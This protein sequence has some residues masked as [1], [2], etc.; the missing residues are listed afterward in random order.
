M[1]AIIVVCAGLVAAVPTAQKASDEDMAAYEI[2]RV[3]VGRDA[4]AHVKL[5]LWCEAHGLE[6]ERTKHLALAVLIDPKQATARGLMGMVA[7]RNR[8][9][10]PSAVPDQVQADAV[11]SASLAEYNGR[12]QKVENTAD[13]QWKLALWCEERGLKAEAEAHLAT[14]ARLDP[15]REAA[16]KRLGCKKVGGR[17]LTAAQIEAEKAEAEAQK[18]A[19]RHWRPLQTKWRGWLGEKT[20]RD[21]AQRYLASV[22]DPRAVP[23]VLAVFAAGDARHQV[24]AVQILGQIDAP[25]ASRALAMLAVFGSA[26]EVRRVAMETLKRRDAR[27]YAGILIAMLQDPIPYEVRP[28]GGPGAPGG[29]FVQGKPFNI[30]RLYSPPAPLIPVGPTDTFGYDAYGRPLL[31]HYTPLLFASGRVPGD[32]ILR[33]VEADEQRPF[34]NYPSLE[35]IFAQAGMSAALPSAAQFTANHAALPSSVDKG[36]RSVIQHVEQTEHTTPADFGFRLLYM[37][38]NDNQ[39]PIGQ[40]MFEAQKSAA[41]AQAQLQNDV[42]AVEAYNSGVSAGNDRVSRALC[43]ATGQDLGD[44]R[45]AWKAWWVNQLGYSYKSPQE[46]PTP[47]FVENV[48]LAYTPQPVIYR[49]ESSATVF[50]MQRMSCFGAGTLVRT[51]RGPEAIESLCVGDQV[52]SQDVKTGALSYQ[53]I[54]VVHHNPPSPT[55]LIKVGEE[56]IVSSPFHRFWRVGQGWVMARDLKPGYILR[57]LDGLSTVV[58][59]ESGPVQPVYNLDVSGAHD[60]FAGAAGALV[61][62]NTLPSLHQVPFDAEP[63]LTALMPSATKP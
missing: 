63:S 23:S 55:F 61:H 35:K 33:G 11:L 54:L 19:D 18:Q 62:D 12:R 24:L 15:S 26:D 43:A 52:L 34:S 53:P 57:L 40:V 37:G 3:S 20:R 7:F 32:Q 5:A 39:I 9:Q 56:T 29:L 10:R 17:W 36:V 25:A 31:H 47:T 28:V 49:I 22:D 2:A 4:D 8:W 13:A 1:L 27:E 45:E 16:W 59:V 48:P 42:A 38:V 46:V 44:D 58:S 50:A 51:L 41:T 30:Q 14:V 60:F 21:Q 6:A